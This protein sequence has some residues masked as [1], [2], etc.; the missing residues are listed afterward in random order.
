MVQPDDF[1]TKIESGFKTQGFG[2]TLISQPPVARTY[3]PHFCLE[4]PTR[5]NEWGVAPLPPMAPRQGPKKVKH[6]ALQQA[7]LDNIGAVAALQL[8]KGMQPFFNVPPAWVDYHGERGKKTSPYHMRRLMEELV[9]DTA[10]QQHALSLIEEPADPEHIMDWGGQAR[11]HIASA[12]ESGQTTNWAKQHWNYTAERTPPVGTS[13][14]GVFF[15][16]QYLRLVRF[17]QI[18]GEKETIWG[19]DGCSAVGLLWA[20]QNQQ[21][22][23]DS[24]TDKI[25]ELLE[26]YDSVH[27]AETRLMKRRR[28]ELAKLHTMSFGTMEK[29]LQGF[30]TY[31]PDGGIPSIQTMLDVMDEWACLMMRSP[32]DNLT[33]VESF[34]H[35][36]IPYDGLTRQDITGCVR[37][38]MHDLEVVRI[39]ATSQADRALLS[40]RAVYV[41]GARLP[42]IEDELLDQLEIIFGAFYREAVAQ[43]PESLG[44]DTLDL[45]W[46][47]TIDVSRFLLYPFIPQ[48]LDAPS[49]RGV[50]DYGGPPRPPTSPASSDADD[51]DMFPFI[52]SSTC[53]SE[54]QA[55]AHPPSPEDEMEMQDA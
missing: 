47:D 22:K 36:L 2:L 54:Y 17:L 14:T 43:Q 32:Y 39:L 21:S 26:L 49:D 8:A 3:M 11:L 33:R 4:L 37:Q 16:I 30:A 28:F 13:D 52:E 35:A 10:Q 41:L 15:D 27:R 12:M 40:H 48:P 9:L 31:R 55:S 5:Q 29:R 50:E 51:C 45:S 53:T 24:T 20:E 25:A 46:Y 38:I 7:R 42:P 18:W 1:Q 34:A 23:W 44:L 6:R 19:R